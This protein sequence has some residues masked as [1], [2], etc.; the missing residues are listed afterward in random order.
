MVT[1]MKINIVI[2]INLRKLIKC[3]I[4][5]S[6]INDKIHIRKFILFQLENWHNFLW[7]IQILSN[8]YNR[9]K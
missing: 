6:K 2:V 1:P 7:N 4:I 5:V 8:L 3:E 9:P